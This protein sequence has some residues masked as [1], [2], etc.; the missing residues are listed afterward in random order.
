MKR[1]IFLF[2]CFFIFIGCSLESVK[3]MPE[4]EERI[5]VRL[6]LESI[7]NTTGGHIDFWIV[8]RTD[9]SG[10]H[11]E[12][13]EGRQEVDFI[14]E[15]NLPFCVTAR[16]VVSFE[17][18]EKLLF[19]EPCGIVY[20]FDFG[21]G[22]NEGDF[23]WLQGYSAEIMKRL[24]LASIESGYNKQEICDYLLQ[25]NWNK[26]RETLILKSEAGGGEKPV[27]NPWM[28]DNQVV[29][30]YISSGSFSATYLTVK[31]S[32]TV[33]IEEILPGKKILSSFIPE[34]LNIEDCG[35]ITLCKN[36][37]GFFLVDAKKLALIN[38]SSEKNVSL[39]YISLPIYR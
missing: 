29:L 15:K 12:I 1:I 39:E 27:F 16:P 21:S 22:N 33:N 11:K 18:G 5:V 37:N 6:P 9:Y 14:V 7:K 23:T 3:E 32:M 38:G 30:N 17:N 26:F 8:E 4:K 28:L 19:F 13:I 35:K 25:F 34:N 31:K 36:L 2:S 20:P 10:R 24:I